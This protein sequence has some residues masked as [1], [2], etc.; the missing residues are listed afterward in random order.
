MRIIRIPEQYQLGIKLL[1]ILDDTVIKQLLVALSNAP[2]VFDVDGLTSAVT[3]EIE[4]LDSSSVEE[5]IKSIFSLYSL[6][7]GENIPSEELAD[8]ITKISFSD[9]GFLEL[10]EEKNELLKQRLIDFLSINGSLAVTARAKNLLSEYER[11]FSSSRIFTDLRPVFESNEEQT[12]TGSLIVHTLKIEYRD[13]EGGK[14]FYIPLDL[15]DLQNL[16]KQ[17]DRAELKEKAVQQLLHKADVRYL[18]PYKAD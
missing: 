11:V 16:R 6:R 7:D 18:D 3:P 17:I 8:N 14:E 5:V 12:I 1:A 2:C 15:Q 4:G 13:S 9:N 10:P